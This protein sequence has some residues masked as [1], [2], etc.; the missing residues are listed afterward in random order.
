MGQIEV[1]WQVY[2]NPSVSIITINVNGL[3]ISIKR[4]KLSYWIKKQD[5]IICCQER[6][7][8]NINVLN[9]KSRKKTKY[10]NIN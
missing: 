10:A 5:P 7:R 2:L 4:Q 6:T 3:N 9:E 1:K 8:V